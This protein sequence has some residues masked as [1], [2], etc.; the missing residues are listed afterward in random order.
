MKVGI[1]TNQIRLHLNYIFSYRFVS[2]HKYRQVDEQSVNKL[3]KIE[4]S[5]SLKNP[6]E[7]YITNA[8]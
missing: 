3:E 8:N 2:E 1:R 4:N 7:K 5:A 6:D